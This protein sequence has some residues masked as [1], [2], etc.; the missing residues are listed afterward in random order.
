MGRGKDDELNARRRE[1][2]VRK[3]VR[4]A[5]RRQPKFQ[6]G[7]ISSF[8]DVIEAMGLPAFFVLF[9][10]LM[11][12]WW[13]YWLSPYLWPDAQRSNGQ[14]LQQ[15][16]HETHL[17]QVAVEICLDPDESL[18]RDELAPPVNGHHPGLSSRS[19]G[20]DLEELR[21]L[22]ATEKVDVNDA[23]FP[24]THHFGYSLLHLA[25]GSDTAVAPEIMAMLINAGVE[26]DQ[27]ATRLDRRT[28]LYLATLYNNEDQIRLLLEAGADID[29]GDNL[30]TSPVYI[31]VQNGHEGLVRLLLEYGADVHKQTKEGW[32]AINVAATECRDIKQ[33]RKLCEYPCPHLGTDGGKPD[34]VG[35]EIYAKIAEMLLEAGAGPNEANKDGAPALHN[36][37]LCESS[38][39]AAALLRFDADPNQVSR[40]SGET[41]L[42]LAAR[43]GSL[44][45][46][47]LLLAEGA[48][49]LQTVTKVVT[50][51]KH[52]GG[53]MSWFPSEIA[54]TN[55]HTSVA[56]RIEEAVKEIEEETGFDMGETA[57]DLRNKYRSPECN[58]MMD[59]TIASGLLTAANRGN[60]EVIMH[61]GAAGEPPAQ[62][63]FGAACATAAPGSKQAGGCGGK[64]SNVRQR[65]ELAGLLVRVYS[66]RVGWAWG[67]LTWL[68]CAD[69][70]DNVPSRRRNLPQGGKDFGAPVRNAFSQ[71]LILQG[72]LRGVCWA[73]EGAG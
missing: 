24:P 30:S 73:Q 18:V 36:A 53:Q 32:L 25:A 54:V 31:A 2:K 15:R 42:W 48:D 14:G 52:R 34:E 67:L 16:T 50:H 19:G 44:E 23:T 47:D 63:G 6:G 35:I 37:V 46:V 55:G 56:N 21:R 4:S 65:V 29:L 26:L 59:N 7:Y 3:E 39:M 28:P 66:P 45:L 43:Q 61:G 60:S 20:C 13:S 51:A 10:T 70:G 11:A 71:P 9:G 5:R 40:L 38:R 68:V 1:R 17:F 49:P 62:T 33:S 69:C 22:L 57:E 58:A 8:D 64:L 12:F 27:R 41:A 72:H